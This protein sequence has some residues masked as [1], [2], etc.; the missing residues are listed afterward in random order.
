LQRIVNHF[1][2]LYLLAQ[3]GPETSEAMAFHAP[4]AGFFVSFAALLRGAN[5]YGATGLL[6]LLLLTGP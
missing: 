2:I 3:F 6:S 1:P 5:G 4:R